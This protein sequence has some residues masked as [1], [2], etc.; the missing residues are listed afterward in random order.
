M[1]PAAGVLVVRLGVGVSGEGRIARTSLGAGATPMDDTLGP[2]APAGVPAVGHS[3]QAPRRR[4]LTVAQAVYCR[5]RGELFW[6][7]AFSGGVAA[8]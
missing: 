8:V 6:V 1:I 4:A 3:A 2:R 5:F 7:N